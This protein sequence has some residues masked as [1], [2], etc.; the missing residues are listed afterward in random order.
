[1][2][3]TLPLTGWI[4]D[5]YGWRWAFY[6]YGV[7]GILWALAWWYLAASGPE[8]HISIAESEALYIIAYRSD[9][10]ISKQQTAGKLAIPWR[11]I[12]CHPV[13]WGLTVAH[14]R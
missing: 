12:V 3:I 7:F 2:A 10:T 13:L 1:M 8:E 6:V 14:L 5:T 4:C 11:A 9:L